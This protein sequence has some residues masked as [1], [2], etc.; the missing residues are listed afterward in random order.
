[1]IATPGSSAWMVNPTTRSSRRR[2]IPIPA[3]SAVSRTLGSG[4]PRSTSTRRKCTFLRGRWRSGGA[5]EVEAPAGHHEHGDPDDAHQ[6]SQLEAGRQGQVGGPAARLLAAGATRPAATWARASRPPVPRRRA[7]AGALDARS[8][9]RPAP[10]RPPDPRP[11]ARGSRARSSQRRCRVRAR[12]R[13]RTTACPWRQVAAPSP[14]PHPTPGA[15]PCDRRTRPV[16]PLSRASASRRTTIPAPTRQSIG[17]TSSPRSCSAKSQPCRQLRYC[18]SYTGRPARRSRPRPGGRR[19]R[20]RV[21]NPR[22][23]EHAVVVDEGDPGPSVSATPRWRARVSPWMRSTTRRV[24]GCS[25][26]R[27]TDRPP[28]CVVGAVVVDD[29]DPPSPSILVLS[30]SA[31]RTSSS[32]RPFSRCR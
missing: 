32:W 19:R 10:R 24:R 14:R 16:D 2:T 21:A 13:A 8:R 25:R 9:R 11:A 18:R 7:S 29:Q 6:P 28:R 20:R 26:S 23:V 17:A 15:V 22:P 1:M 30:A 31:A 5:P 3:S 4:A 12:S 27:P